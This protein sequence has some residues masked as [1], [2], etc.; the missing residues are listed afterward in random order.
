M[1]GIDNKEYFNNTK[2]EKC[3]ECGNALVEKSG[4]YGKFLGCSNY[5]KCKFTKNIRS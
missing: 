2:E 3:P 4:K 5:P 1:S